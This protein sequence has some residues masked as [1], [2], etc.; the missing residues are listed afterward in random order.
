MVLRDRIYGNVDIKSPVLIEL[1][2]SRP[3]QRLKN[4][5]Q[6][7][8][9]DEYYFVKNY[10]RYEHSKGVLML[11][12]IL[13]ASEEEQIAGLIHDV[14]HTAFSHVI[15]FIYGDTNKMQF[16]DNTLKGYIFNS[17]IPKILNN[18]GINL[19]KVINFDDHSLLER[20][21]PELCADRIDYAFREF[22]LEKARY[23]LAN[24]KVYK[25]KI[26]FAN[27]VAAKTFAELYL[28]KQNEHWGS[29]QSISRFKIFADL[30][31]YGIEHKFLN[32]EDFWKDD[33]F[34]VNKLNKSNDSHVIKVLKVLSSDNLAESEKSSTNIKIKFRYVDPLYNSN[35][36][37]N[38]LSQ[39][40]EVFSSSLDKARLNNYK[41]ILIPTI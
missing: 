11:L 22:P 1:L 21:I 20:P 28:N 6:F 36:Q 12:N 27:K 14:S 25:G 26:I 10:S 41:G 5:N 16:Q 17:D 37:L 3:L 33:K 7:G 4:I 24:L 29:F 8:V 38:Q 40:S 34:I 18:Y 30:L 19:N 39:E 32:K 2:N 15:D 35:G 31:K 13:G 23:C 9:P